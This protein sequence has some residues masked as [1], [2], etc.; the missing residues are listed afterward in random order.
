V[1]TVDTPFDAYGRATVYYQGDDANE[2]TY[3][4]TGTLTVPDTIVLNGEVCVPDQKTKTM[5]LNVAEI[6][7]TDPAIFRWGIG[8]YWSLSCTAT[9]GAV[10]TRLMPAL[11][12]TMYINLTRCGGY[13]ESGQIATP[14]HMQGTYTKNCGFDGYVSGTWDLRHCVE[15]LPC[16]PG[17]VCRAGTTV[18]TAGIASCVDAGPAAIPARPSAGDAT[19]KSVCVPRSVRLGNDVQAFP[20]RPNVLAALAHPSPSGAH[21][22]RAYRHCHDARA[23]P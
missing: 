12:D 1:Q 5:Q 3:L 2:T 19:G 9:S 10:T 13:Y 7:K 21:P 8:T 18:C 22:R 6:T 20:I 14:E 4:L 11:F 23:G 16:D 17:G 15:G